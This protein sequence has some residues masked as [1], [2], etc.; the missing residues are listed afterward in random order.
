V[1]GLSDAFTVNHNNR[2]VYRPAGGKA[3]SPQT[4]SRRASL[5]IVATGHGQPAPLEPARSAS[6]PALSLVGGSQSST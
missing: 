1:I 2:G 6:P 3:G 5:G 4:D